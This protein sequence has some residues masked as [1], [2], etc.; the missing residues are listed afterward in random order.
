[1]ELIFVYS[2]IAYGITNI[3]VFGSIFQNWRD[4][5]DAQSPTFFGKLFSCPMCLSVWVGFGL[6]MVFQKFNINTPMTEIGMFLPMNYDMLLFVGKIFL[7]GMFAGGIVWLIHTIQEAF[8]R[9]FN[10]Q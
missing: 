9:A 1:M 10:N 8:E 5:W 2:I 4:F 6:S 3:L 7:D